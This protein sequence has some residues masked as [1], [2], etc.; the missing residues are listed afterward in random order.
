MFPA[1]CTWLFA[2]QPIDFIRCPAFALALLPKWASTTFVVGSIFCWDARHW[3][4]PT[5]LISNS[6]QAYADG[7]E[8]G[9][10][11]HIYQEMRALLNEKQWRQYLAMEAQQRGSVAEVAME[12]GASRNTVKR[13]LHELETG[14]CYRPGERLRQTG[15]GRKKAVEQDATGPRRSGKPARS[16]R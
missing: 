14:E 1:S 12:A 16:Q 9:S 10:K 5:Y 6:H 4:L 8:T 11:Q 3:L 13:G 2:W 7:M 15:G